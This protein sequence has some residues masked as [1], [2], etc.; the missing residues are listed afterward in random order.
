MIMRKCIV[1]ASDLV[2]WPT[3]SKKVTIMFN[4]YKRLKKFLYETRF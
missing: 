4:V 1:E 2:N 3:S